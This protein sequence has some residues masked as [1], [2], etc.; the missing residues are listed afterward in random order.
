LNPV[1]RFLRSAADRLYRWLVPPYRTELIEDTLPKRLR[2]RRLYIIEEDGFLEQAAM[3][4][5]CGCKRIL[6]M[7]LL[8]DERPC[9]KLTRHDDNTVT[10]HPSVWR[11]K[12]CGS[13]FWFR[14]GYVH[15]CRG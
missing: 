7:N 12:D 11:K 2:R 5:P 9:W 8:P 10:L 13:H 14:K 1:R 3:L 15:W 6:H 4:C